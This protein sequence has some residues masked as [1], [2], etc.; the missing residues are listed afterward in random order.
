[1]LRKKELGG[2]LPQTP[3][4]GLATVQGLNGDYHDYSVQAVHVI[5]R[6]KKGS[7]FPNAAMKAAL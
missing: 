3:V 2:A 5:P 4:Q 6:K 1:M 7:K